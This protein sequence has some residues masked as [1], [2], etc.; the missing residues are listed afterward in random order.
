MRAV[1]LGLAVL[2]L[3]VSVSA[4][5]S[6][7]S[8]QTMLKQLQNLIVDTLYGGESEE[9]I[10]ATDGTIRIPL[11]RTSADV[12]NWSYTKYGAK[13][14]PTVPLQDFMNAQY[15]GPVSIGTPAQTFNVIFDT[16][17]SNLWVPS[18]K[19]SGCN[20]KKYDST[21]STSYKKNGSDF[22]IHYGSGSLS[23]FVSQETVTWGGVRIPKVDFAEATNEPGAAFQQGKFDGILGMAF[24]S[25][26]VDDMDPVFQR[27]WEQKAFPANMF[28]FYVPSVSGS[29]GELVLGGYDHKHFTGDLAWQPLSSDTYWEITVDDIGVTRM[30]SS[31]K[32][33]IVDTGTSLLAGPKAEVD[34]I[35]K[36]VGAFASPLGGQYILS[37]SSVS[38]L[39]DFEVSVAG[40]K[41]TLTG[42]QYVMKV[43]MFGFPV[44]LLGM[45]GIDIPAP[46]G[47]LWILG[48]TFLR[49]H[50]TVFD[51]GGNRVGFGNIARAEEETDTLFEDIPDTTS[52]IMDLLKLDSSKDHF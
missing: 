12:E 17:S 49:Q 14:P 37:C 44:C 47:P 23:G 18:S 10:P 46:R 1:L 28:A 33:A 42:D 30:S 43:K 5:S 38:S 16:G 36:S 20:H 19:C 41:F 45:M 52:I 22:E 6:K 25:I 39:P 3:A 21:S 4:A 7:E 2:V 26:S 34:K 9:G 40:K 8:L 24:R 13:S 48:D 35:A 15:Y 11:R 27:G 51:V 32:T 50:Y 31:C 29:E